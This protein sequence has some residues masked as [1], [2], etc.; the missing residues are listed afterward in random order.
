MTNLA[1]RRANIDEAH[2][3]RGRTSAHGDRASRALEKGMQLRQGD[4]GVRFA[5]KHR[6]PFE[7]KRHNP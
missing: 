2:R 7:E 1:Q 6:D 3:G 5:M 4:G